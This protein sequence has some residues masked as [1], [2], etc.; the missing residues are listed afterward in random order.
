MNWINEGLEYEIR[1]VFEKRYKRILT[2]GEVIEIGENLE[3]VTE[4]ILK[5]KWRQQI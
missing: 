2:D 3:A 5:L 4:E 1:K